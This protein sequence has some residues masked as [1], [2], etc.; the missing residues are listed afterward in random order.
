MSEKSKKE[1]SSQSQP[2]QSAQTQADAA[3]LEQQV[4]QLKQQNEQLAA[5][6]A[7][8]TDKLQRLGADYANYQKRVPRQI[9]DAVAYE[10]RSLVRALIPS[11]DNFEHMFSGFA[12]LQND[13]S[14]AK[15]LDGMR[16]ILAHLLDALKQIGVQ[17]ISAVG[18]PFDP[19]R[20]EA[21]TYRSQPDKDNG[22]VLEE[23]LPCYL[24]G[25]ETVRPA[26]VVVNKIDAPATPTDASLK[27]ENGPQEETTDIE[28]E[29]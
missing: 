9:A 11:L 10:K 15:L 18:Q 13:P 27:S 14:A 24:L 19:H 20:H 17:K 2:A 28:P 3:P 12:D 8:L 6:V 25:D 29:V 22:I 7:Q 16:L 23:Y 5:Q 21:M 26:K 4:E 1:H